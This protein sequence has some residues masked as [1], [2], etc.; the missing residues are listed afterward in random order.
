MNGHMNGPRSGAR[1]V[2]GAARVERVH[3]SLVPS[4]HCGPI[5]SRTH[6]RLGGAGEARKKRGKRGDNHRKR[7]IHTV[8]VGLDVNEAIRKVGGRGST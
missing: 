4:L 5:R 7:L 8:R 1:G 6:A 3:N 2:G